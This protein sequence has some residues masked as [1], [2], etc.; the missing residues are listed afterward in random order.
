MQ[1]VGTV[2]NMLEE[3]L[4]PSQYSS[5]PFE[6][7]IP[8]DTAPS[9]AD[10]DPRL[11]RGS[12]R[13]ILSFVIDINGN[14]HLA[15]TSLRDLMNEINTAILELDGDMANEETSSPFQPTVRIDKSENDTKTA[16]RARFVKGLDLHGSIS[17]AT[18]FSID[19]FVSLLKLR[20]LRRLDFNFN[21][22]EEKSF[23]I[24]RHVVLFAMVK[25]FFYSLVAICL[26]GMVY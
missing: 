22:N 7:T 2:P 18:Q 12:T 8:A 21:P 20:D 16:R 25:L 19:T 1:F 10:G 5:Q 17:G 26:L 11:N 9:M 14:T 24:R 13:E 3:E 15:E 6:E 23:L 4:N